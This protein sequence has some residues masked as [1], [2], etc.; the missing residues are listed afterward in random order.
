MDTDSVDDGE[1]LRSLYEAE[2]SASCRSRTAMASWLAVVLL[3]AF[4]LLDAALFPDRLR[5]LLSLRLAAVGGLLAFIPMQRAPWAERR[6]I[7]L[8]LALLAFLGATV[9]A[10]VVL[11][12]GLASPYYPGLLL[13][14]VGVAALM[15]WPPRHVVLTS[16]VLIGEYLAAVACAPRPPAAARAL[17]TPMAFMLSTGI[18]T[19]IASAVNERLRRD[20]FAS[21]AALATA[22]RYKDEFLANVSHDLRTPL[23]VAIGYAQLL[24]EGAF[25][26]LTPEQTDALA[27]IL[28]S[29]TTQLRLVDDLLELA[30]MERGKLAVRREPVAV[31]DLVPALREMMDMLLRNRPV[32]FVVDVAAQAVALADR[33]RLQQVLTNLLANAA[34][35]TPRGSIR[36]AAERD[37][38]LVR[39]TVADTGLGMEE[40]LRVRATEPFVRGR[41]DQ[42]GFGLGLAIVAK[43]VQ[44]LGGELVVQSTPGVGTRLEVRLEAAPPTMDAPAI[45]PERDEV[46][47]VSDL[48]AR[49]S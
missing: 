37:G 6:V 8:G 28:R 35:F 18:I 7:A 46:L 39:I 48:R 25:G 45:P 29:A 33:E 3:A 32:R 17:V 30:R 12:G 44:L 21:R 14:Q 4:G 11:T 23:N 13:V 2:R 5:L 24:A 34:K 16:V 22:L 10:L 40:D 31:A 49:A 20:A 36:L 15:P 38:R 47:D 27:R 1:G 19:V 43:L 41:H 42:G 9:A 26:P